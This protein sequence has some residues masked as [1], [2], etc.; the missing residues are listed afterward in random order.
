MTETFKIINLENN[1]DLI[2]IYGND[3]KT[4]L[5]GQI[6]N[7]INLVSEENVILS[8]FCNPKGRLLAIFHITK[9]DDIFYLICPKSI[10]E[11]IVKKLSLFVLR[12]EVEISINSKKISL[13]GFIDSQKNSLKNIF[14]DI[15]QENYHATMN[16]NYL[17][18]KIPC[19]NERFMALCLPDFKR[20]ILDDNNIY[21]KPHDDWKIKDI[22]FGIPYIYSETQENFIPQSLNLDL[23]NAI[24]FKK[25]CYTGQEIVARTHYLG[26]IKRRM[27]HANLKPIKE[28]I[29]GEDLYVKDKI[30]GK[31]ID[32]VKHNKKIEC[33]IELLVEEKDNEVMLQNQL[34]NISNLK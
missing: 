16:D 9:F 5:Q 21:L 32:F 13:L 25:G 22:E 15:P 19:Q 11:S 2:E 18:I 29:V 20:K 31:L 12:S 7:D 23:L 28:I 3:S 27:F 14:N 30:V 26:K 8:G 6:T 34:L 4:F 17:L 24:N 1:F 10:S 33:L